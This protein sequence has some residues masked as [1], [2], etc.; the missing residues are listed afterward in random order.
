M[1]DIA[2]VSQILEATLSS[3]KLIRRKAEDQ[4]IG[5]SKNYGLLLLHFFF[6]K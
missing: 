5:L 2:N 1:S 3:N 6:L 4:L